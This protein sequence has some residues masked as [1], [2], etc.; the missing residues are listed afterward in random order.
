MSSANIIYFW[1][2]FDDAAKAMI[3]DQCSSMIQ[4]FNVA[5]DQFNASFDLNP[6]VLIQSSNAANA[7]APAANATSSGWSAWW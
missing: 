1:L 5:E 4:G 2:H 6:E 3:F 7:T